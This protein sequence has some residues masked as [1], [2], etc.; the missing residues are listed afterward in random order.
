MTKCGICKQEVDETKEDLIRITYGP[1]ET[2]VFEGHG[3][4]LVNNRRFLVNSL[5]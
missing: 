2:L 4:C 5:S 3:L 1:E